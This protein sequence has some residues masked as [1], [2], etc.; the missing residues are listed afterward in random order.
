MAENSILTRLKHGWNAFMNRD[1]TNYPYRGGSYGLRPD[2]VALRIGNEQSIIASIYNRIS[3]D[4]ASMTFQHVRLDEDGLFKE[5]IDSGLNNCLTMEANMDQSAQDFKQDIVLSM[6]DEGC[7]AVLPVETDK[8]P[9]LTTSYEIHSL[10][11]AKIVEWF[12]D[13]VKINA[14][15]QIEGKKEDI[16]LPKRMVAII[17]NPFYSV[18]NEPNSTLRRLIH[19]LNLLDAVDE[20]S[21]SGKLDLIIQLPYVVKSPA[22]EAQAEVRR[23]RIEEQLSGSK[24]GI[25]YTDSTEKITQLNRSI[26]NNLLKQI[27]YLTSMLYSQLGLTA[28][29]FDGTANEVVLANYYSRTV[30]PIAAAITNELNRKFLTK[31]ARSQKQSIKY[32]R[33]PFKVASLEQIASAGDSMTR[34]AIMSSNEIRDKIGLKAVESEDANSL[35]NKNL[36]AETGMGD[37]PMPE[38]GMGEEEGYYQ[39][40]GYEDV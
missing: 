19:K 18:M 8:N 22:R 24:Y 26:E 11:T 36:S 15:N 13:S 1:P 38:A 12:P 37:M 39:N 20:Q 2:R 16:I 7:V 23:K 28:N 29:V 27:E 6:F 3:L 9:R 5:T 30:E 33:D 25:A 4:V 21:G 40:G 14:Y 35:R 31:T 32:F 17:Q 34:N 10:R